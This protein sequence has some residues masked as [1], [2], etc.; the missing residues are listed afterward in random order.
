MQTY[1]FIGFKMGSSLVSYRYKLWCAA[2]KTWARTSESRIL[3]NWR[4]AKHPMYII[5]TCCCL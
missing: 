3:Q 1:V 2:A 4:T 5:Q